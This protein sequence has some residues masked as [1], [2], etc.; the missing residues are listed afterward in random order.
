MLDSD[1]SRW[2]GEHPDGGGLTLSR[3]SS[4]GCGTCSSSN[5]MPLVSTVLSTLT[6]KF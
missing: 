4:L 1:V 5:L 6:G 3:S 2:G